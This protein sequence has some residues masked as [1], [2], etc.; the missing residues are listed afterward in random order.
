MCPQLG[1]PTATLP[2]STWEPMPCQGRARLPQAPALPVPRG[3]AE[4]L[5]SVPCGR[6]RP[7]G[8]QARHVDRT[9]AATEG[10]PS[11]PG[12][13]A[14]SAR[15]VWR[16]GLARWAPGNVVLAALWVGADLGPSTDEQGGLTWPGR[17]PARGGPLGNASC[18][19]PPCPG[20]P[21]WS[22]AIPCW[23]ETIWHLFTLWPVCNLPAGPFSKERQD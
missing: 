4:R 5:T 7:G 21:S 17:L 16:G 1:T 11:S 6:C 18:A 15:G 10:L 3:F 9:R 8:R 12:R 14:P 19:E 2:P 13:A 22:P 23:K 20:R